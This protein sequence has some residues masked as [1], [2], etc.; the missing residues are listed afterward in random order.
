MSGVDLSRAIDAGRVLSA[1]REDDGFTL[2]TT[3]RTGERVYRCRRIVLAT[4]GMAGPNRLDIAGEDLP[5]VTH[6][7]GDPHRYFRTRLLIVGGMNSALEAALRCWR[8]GA[9]VTITNSSVVNN[10]AGLEGGGIYT[11]T[12]ATISVGGSVSLSRMRG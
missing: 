1:R 8:A 2:R 6:Y 4:G 9:D 12:I 7:L 5:H 10:T 3:T 11:T